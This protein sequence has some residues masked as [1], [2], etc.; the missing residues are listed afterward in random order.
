ML[1]SWPWMCCTVQHYKQQQQQTYHSQFICSEI[2]VPFD[3]ILTILMEKHL[4]HLLQLNNGVILR[5]KTLRHTWKIPPF[6]LL[7]GKGYQAVLFKAWL[8]SASSSLPARFNT[9]WRT[10][11]GFSKIWSCKR[12][13]LK[14]SFNNLWMKC[15]GS[16]N[17]VAMTVVTFS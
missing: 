8:Q 13:I 16:P 4:Q 11:A 6:W 3:W 14:P 1:R 12:L 2:Q 7:G 5:K 9:K 15:L 10:L 17:K